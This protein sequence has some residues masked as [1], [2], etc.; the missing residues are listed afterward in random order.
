MLKEHAAPR[1]LAEAI[2]FFADP[3]TAFGFVVTL[4]WPSGVSCPRC[5]GA[6]PSFLKSRRIWKCKACRQ[7]FSIKVGTIFEDSPLGLDKWLPALWMLANAKNGI[8]SYELGRAL[9][10]T[11]KT[12]WF[13][14]GRIR[15]AMQAKSFEKWDGEV[16]ADESFIGGKRANM[17]KA[18]QD[19]LPFNS[20]RQHMQNVFGML[21]RSKQGRP[22]KVRLAHVGTIRKH[23]L[24]KH[25]DATV[26]AGAT[27]YTDAHA[28]YGSLAKKVWLEKY[29][30]MVI[31][32]AIAYAKGAIHT[33]G[34]E[35]FWSLLKRSLKGTYI[36]VDPFHLFRYLDEQAFRF[37]ERTENDMTRF[38]TVLRETIGRKLTYRGLIGADYTIS[39]T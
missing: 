2:R 7:Q 11:Q 20:G 38:V 25:I 15:H 10:V 9:G 28:A 5:G 21:R 24:G 4:R 18:K 39:T 13:M 6:D 17:H 30:H 31:D 32:H 1:T 26:E 3:D 34:L 37:N 22:S 29:R 14:L 12:A 36:S 8:S 23:D 33:N 27:L 35:N 19:R 16:E